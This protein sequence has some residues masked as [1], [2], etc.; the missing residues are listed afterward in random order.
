MPAGAGPCAQL[1]TP[2]SAGFFTVQCGDFLPFVLSLW[3]LAVV[4]S[5]NALETFVGLLCVP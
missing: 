1:M 2:S 3:E 5:W 4:C